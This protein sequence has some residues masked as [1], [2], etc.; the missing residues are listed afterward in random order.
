MSYSA[1]NIADL[2]MPNFPPAFWA[3]LVCWEHTAVI[4]KVVKRKEI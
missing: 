3:R 1:L 4:F 2:G